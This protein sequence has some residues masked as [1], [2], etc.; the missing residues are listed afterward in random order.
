MII[1]WISSLISS[2]SRTTAP[3]KEGTLQGE[4]LIARKKLAGAGRKQEAGTVYGS[5]WTDAEREELQA[6]YDEH[7]RREA[8]A[9]FVKTHPHRTVEGA[10]YQ[11]DRNLNRRPQPQE[12][13][14]R[15]LS[16]LP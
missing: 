5:R 14:L 12:R 10:R 9:K 3:P 15:P 6:L 16:A 2:A 4:A 7:G 8:A 11:I 13:S 1:T